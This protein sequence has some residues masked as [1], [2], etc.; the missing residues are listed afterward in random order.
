MEFLDQLLPND[1][2]LT[3][4]RRLAATLIKQYQESKIA[5]GM[6]CW[7]TVLIL[8]ISTWLEKLWNEYT[9]QVIDETPLLL[10]SDQEQILWEEIIR[11][12]PESEYLLQVSRTAKL[13]L[14]AW[15]LLKQWKIDPNDPQLAIT[16]DSQFFQKWASTFQLQCKQQ[17]LLDHASLPDWL[18]SIIATKKI[19]LPTTIHL[20]G[21]IEIS[22][23]IHALLNTCQSQHSSLRDC[24]ALSRGNPSGTRV[25]TLN[26]KEHEIVSMARWTKALHEKNPTAKIGCII[27]DLGNCRDQVQRIF[28]DAFSDK[29]EDTVPPFNIS[30]GKKLTDFPIIHT[31]LQLLNLSKTTISFEKFS[32]LLRTPFLGDAERESQKRALYENHLRNINVSTVS[33][34]TL[35]TENKHLKFSTYCPSLVKRLQRYADNL[36]E[37]KSPASPSQWANFFTNALTLLGWPGERSLNSEELQVI[38]NGWLPLLT[39]F[40]KL[41]RIV[42]SISH[43]KALHY[44][45]LLAENSVFQPQTPE[46]PIQLLGLL[47]AAGLSFDYL[48]V[49]G[50]DDTV[51]PAQ[52]SPNPFIPLRLQKHLNMPNASA[53]RELIYCQKLTEQFIQSSPTVLFSYA[54]ANEKAMQR[55]SA[56]IKKFAKTN[57]EELSLSDFIPTAQFIFQS[58]QLESWVDT[59]TPVDQNEAIYGGA[60]IFKLQAACPFKAFSEL[61]LHARELESPTIGLRPQDRGKLLH[62]ALELIWQQLKDSATLH[63]I[64]FDQLN[65]IISAC[66]SNAF[67]DLHFI[68]PNQKYSRYI[69][70]EKKR[71]EKIIEQWLDFEKTRPPFKTVAL[72]QTSETVI[73]NLRIKLRI[74]RIDELLTGEKIIIDYKTGKN[75]PIQGWFG[76]RPDEPQ[77]PLYCITETSNITGISFAELHPDAISLK[78]ISKTTINWDEQVNQWRTVLTKLGKDFYQGISSVDPKNADDTCRLCHLHSLCRIHES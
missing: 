64:D 33:L 43:Q 31:A 72:E 58:K 60:T 19:T 21:F 75:N 51:W 26:D 24:E 56:L 18:S 10:T 36:S 53:D 27:P 74:D 5:Q 76:D 2:V 11:K 9:S 32:H 15:E 49:M 69:S 42:S 52:P 57:I 14:S 22:P 34:N 17:N 50:L 12:S 61:R 47:E 71:M 23:Q 68:Q 3:P 8:P 6:L 44:L 38:Q 73:E 63:E 1:V 29:Q 28:Y 55:P 78:G 77:L 7:P 13:A 16:E 4:N 67:N 35:L 66:I 48:W 59:T 45:I 54:I 40:S 20:V 65:N 41:D 46:T 30:A 70:I 37:I 39:E 25:I 62:K